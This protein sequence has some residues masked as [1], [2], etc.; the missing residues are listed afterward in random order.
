MP[1]FPILESK[2]FH[3]PV[4]SLPRT[5]NFEKCH[6]IS[7]RLSDPDAQDGGVSWSAE[8]DFSLW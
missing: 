2:K 8:V 5:Q 4:G 3:F 7:D 1:L 6:K